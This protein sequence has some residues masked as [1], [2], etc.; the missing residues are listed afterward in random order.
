MHLIIRKAI[1][2]KLEALF[3]ILGLIVRLPYLVL[4][5]VFWDESFSW[6]IKQHSFT[7][8]IEATSVDTHPPLYYI[9]LKI[10]TSI[11]GD[12]IY[13]M[14]SLSILF[15]ICT[16]IVLFILIRRISKNITKRV[17]IYSILTLFPLLMWL[18]VLSRMYSMAI[19]FVLL[20][21]IFLDNYIKSKKIFNLLLYSLF[22]LISLYTLNVS[23][24]IW[25]GANIFYLL[26]IFKFNLNSI[27][28]KAKSAD[29]IKW[30]LFQIIIFVL[31]LPWFIVAIHQSSGAAVNQLKWLPEFSPVVII[32]IPSV[33]FGSQD[34]NGSNSVFLMGTILWIFFLLISY[35][36]LKS[37]FTK[38]KYNNITYIFL[39]ESITSVLF[40]SLLS[41][42]NSITTSR[43]LFLSAVMFL[44]SAISIVKIKNVY[45]KP[46]IFSS[47]VVTVLVLAGYNSIYPGIQGESNL[48][49]FVKNINNDNHTKLVITRQEDYYPIS[50]QQISYFTRSNHK[51][52]KLDID[53]DTGDYIIYTKND[54]IKL[55]DVNE[56]FYYFMMS[57]RF[58]LTCRDVKGF[59]KEYQMKKYEL[60]YKYTLCKYKKIV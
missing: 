1:K 2:Y 51:N 45:L 15:W 20:S 29:F 41:L 17:L 33:L 40:L 25:I 18:S 11:F 46:I 8:I 22:T 12:N 57:L 56:D 14:R 5:P 31:Y 58:D 37:F 34:I 19:F 44:V 9:V 30:I 16:M 38:K 52:I 35:V 10:W 26:N 50:F 48:N 28:S 43:A 60:D 23:L 32:Q 49:E 27:I 4:E 39:F 3:L 42:K 24:F 6:V 47:L 59:E 7:G 55:E 21:V 36:I 13:V 54:F 53:T